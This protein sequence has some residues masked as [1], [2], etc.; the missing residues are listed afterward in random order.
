MCVLNGFLYTANYTGANLWR[1][2]IPGLQSVEKFD[3]SDARQYKLF[4]IGEEQNRPICMQSDSFTKSIIIGSQAN[5]GKYG[6]AL[7]YYNVERN[8]RYTKRNIV[9][10]HTI[11]NVE[12]DQKDRN[13]AYLGTSGINN[14]LPALKEDAHIVKWDLAARSILFNVIPKTNN[15]YIRSLVSFEDKLFCVNYDTTVF[16]LSGSTGEVLNNK[17]SLR[18]GQMLYSVDGNLYGITSTTLQIVDPKTLQSKVIKKG[19]ATLDMLI[20]DVTTNTLFLVANDELW[21]YR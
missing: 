12:F 5:Y 4:D 1:F 13:I 20:E 18:L 6:G 17:N 21:S 8:E 14:G 16:I 19:F 7:T 15:L 11:Q 10:N 3:W 9:P 2:P